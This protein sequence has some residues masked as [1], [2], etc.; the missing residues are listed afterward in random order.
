MTA[1]TTTEGLDSGARRHPHPATRRRTGA[2]RA[3]PAAALP[4]LALA[5]ALGGCGTPPKPP[6]LVSYDELRK[7]PNLESTRKRF[8]DLV[9]SSEKYGRKAEEE[10]E[11]NDVD[12]STRAA[13]MAQ[14]KLKTA[15][16]RFEQER[17]K[18]RIQA[19]NGEQAEAD[20]TL[21]EI[22]KD[23]TA[24]TEQIALMERLASARKNA[25]AEK[26]RLSEQM[27]T[28]AAEKQALSQ[29]LATE[30]KRAEAQLALRTADTVEATKY[31]APDYHAATNMLAKAD[32]EIKQKNWAGAQVSLEVARKSAEKATA[33]A[34]PAYEQ[35][36]QATENK[37]RNEALARDAATLPGVS[38][39]LER[40]GDL[41]R[42]VVAVGDLFGRMQ[43]T[44]AP[45]KETALDPVAR[46]ISKY[47][48][49]PVQIVGHTDNKGKVGELLALSQAR[50][51]SVFSSL[52]ARGVEARRLM[53]S[54]QGP[55]E[56]IA[57]NRSTPGR[58]RN[59]RIEV[60]FL[61]H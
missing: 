46:L 9:A 55:N 39:R 37:A 16:A 2:R 40:R 13:L 60:I 53:V 54:G 34:K 12:E 52:V 10:W 23:L 15:L 4:A 36:T 47:P 45:G 42:L 1:T 7:D 59:N 26:A 5:M 57:D 31:A 51:Q 11:S 17:A 41:Q 14:I 22:N 33:A 18:S 3:W 27:S 30:Q 28:A 35:A 56:P 58:S 8:P 61:Y 6:A 20:E 25:D 38:V 24:T 49:Y 48:G 50:A 29:Q 44:L 32:E 43:T 19:L 21:A